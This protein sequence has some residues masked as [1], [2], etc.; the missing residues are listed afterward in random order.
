MLLWGNRDSLGLWESLEVEGKVPLD[1]ENMLKQKERNGT[2]FKSRVQV[3]PQTII[4][5]LI[6][7]FLWGDG[8]PPSSLVF[9]YLQCIVH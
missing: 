2:S 9:P 6:S 1:F 8:L 4:P 3:A 7:D 5:L